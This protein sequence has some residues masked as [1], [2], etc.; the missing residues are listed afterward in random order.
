MKKKKNVHLTKI[1]QA[2]LLLAEYLEDPTH[3]QFRVFEH[4]ADVLGYRVRKSPQKQKR[5]P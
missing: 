2:I 1:E 5:K 3:D 4:V